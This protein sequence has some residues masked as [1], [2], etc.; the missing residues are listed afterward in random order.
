MVNTYCRT[1]IA[2]LLLLFYTLSS[3]AQALEDNFSVNNT[4]EI[5]Q[6]PTKIKGFSGLIFDKN[7]ENF[8]AVSDY[9]KIYLIDK[10][11]HILQTLYKK[12]GDLEGITL[13][14]SNQDIYVVDEQKMKVLKLNIE[15]KKLDTFLKIKV[16]NLKRNKGLEAI[17]Y[18][19]DTLYIGNQF[20]PKRLFKYAVKTHQLSFIDLDYAGYLSDMFYDNTD[21]TLWIAN[22]K[23][24]K[25]YQYSLDGKLIYEQNIDFIQKAEALTVDREQKILWIGCDYTGILHKVKL[26]K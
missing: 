22:S 25:I 4:D 16:P 12:G 8:Y 10:Q 15:D 20:A 1:S 19:Q 3:R 18:G 11:G 26:N 13:D 6:Y 7:K 24:K 23:A 14:P 9:G 5:A 2:L 21:H 17:A